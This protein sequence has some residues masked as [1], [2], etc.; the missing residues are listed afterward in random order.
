MRQ[1]MDAAGGDALGRFRALGLAYVA[2]ATSHPAHFRVMFGRQVAD[3][4]RHPT[5]ATAAQAA[6][7]L[8]VEALARCQQAG[9]AQPGD[10]KV[11]ALPAWAIVHGLSALMVEGHLPGRESPADA[12]ELAHAVTAAVFL[13]LGTRPG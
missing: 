7:G 4:S 12:Q 3:A 6:F 8:L 1:A 13:G 11:L 5:L 2:F 10:P 9:L